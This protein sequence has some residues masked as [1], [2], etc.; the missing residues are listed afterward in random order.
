MSDLEL[1]RDLNKISDIIRNLMI[2]ATIE[3]NTN[4]LSKITC[5]IEGCHAA[6]VVSLVTFPIIAKD[7]KKAEILLEKAL[8]L[9]A[10]RIGISLDNMGEKLP[11]LKEFIPKASKSQEEIAKEIKEIIANY[12]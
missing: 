1:E 12:D 5:M 6:I 9:F 10:V 4:K 7:K 2:A 3:G 11:H 8:D